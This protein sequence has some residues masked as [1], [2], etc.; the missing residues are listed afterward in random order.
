MSHLNFF[1]FHFLIKDLR[2]GVKMLRGE[3]INDVYCIPSSINPQVHHTTKSQLDEWHKRLGHP[4]PPIVR[5]I[6]HSSD[7]KLNSLSDSKFHCTSCA[8]NKSHKLP[9]SDKSLHSSKPL[10]LI[11]SDVWGPTNTSIDGFRYYL[12]FVDHYSKY[13]W[14][15]PM[16]KKSDVAILFPQFKLLVEKFFQHSIISL[17]TDNGGEYLSLAPILN[18]H[19]VSHFKTPPYTPEHNGTSERRHRHI[20]EIGLAL[21]HTASLPISYWSYAFQTAVYLINRLP[22]SVLKFQSPF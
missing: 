17:Y 10:E 16:K 20:V 1:P 22:T 6:F 2:T 12:I 13:I 7:L 15:Y 5:S 3:N 11:Y 21:L 18:S 19:G 4:A 8:L 9:F 14:L